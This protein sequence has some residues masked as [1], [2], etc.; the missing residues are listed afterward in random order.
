MKF[1]LDRLGNYSDEEILKEIRRVAELVPGLVLSRSAFGKHA[2]VSL[3][4]VAHRFGT[5]R[6][7]LELAG[8]GH[9]YGGHAVP[10]KVRARLWTQMTDDEII[11]EMHRVRR[12]NGKNTLTTRD[13]TRSDRIGVHTIKR[14]FGSW[15]AA[16]RKAGIPKSPGRRLPDDVCFENMLRVWTHYGRAP[17]FEE[18]GRPPSTVSARPY[19]LRFGN[20]SGALRAFVER[21]NSDGDPAKGAAEPRQADAAPVTRKAKPREQGDRGNVRHGL[22]FRVLARDR[23]KCVLCGRSPATD[24]ECSL[25][26]DH[27]IPFSRGGRTTEE[28][29]R[30]LCAECNVGR[31]NRHET[32]SSVSIPPCLTTESG[33]RTARLRPSATVRRRAPDRYARRSRPARPAR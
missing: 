32:D 12:Q 10:Q 15:N 27:I 2:K 16:L 4:T 29:L 24:P 3:T 5:W 23:F 25:H 20:W 26:V 1:V 33:G 8:I 28:N 19:L 9:R 14:R 17:R 30:T 21:A 18:M 11:A 6:Q 7:A 13:V 22:R 31:G